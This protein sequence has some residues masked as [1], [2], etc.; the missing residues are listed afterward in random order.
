MAY[1]HRLLYLAFA[2]MVEYVMRQEQTYCAVSYSVCRATIQELSKTVHVWRTA[3]L[4]KADNSPE[5]SY[6]SVCHN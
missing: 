2:L 6:N 4:L 3:S 5:Y 1:L